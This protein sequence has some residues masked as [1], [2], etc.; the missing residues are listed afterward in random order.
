[1]LRYLHSTRDCAVP[2]VARGSATE[3]V[4]DAVEVDCV[5]DVA[6]AGDSARLLRLRS[7]GSVSVVTASLCEPERRVDG[8]PCSRRR[9]SPRSRTRRGSCS[10][11]GRIGRRRKTCGSYKRREMF[12]VNDR[13]SFWRENEQSAVIR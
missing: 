7:A 4:P 5:R 12:T 10:R 11:K 6:A 2:S 9:A 8:G 3:V 13:S 1:M